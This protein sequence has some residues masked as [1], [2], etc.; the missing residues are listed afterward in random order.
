MF[1]DL[2]RVRLICDLGILVIFLNINSHQFRENV[3][4]T[5]VNILAAKALHPR[6]AAVAQE[7]LI[8]GKD[9]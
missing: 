3:E 5:M 8:S 1:F 6:V 4:F 7:N 2:S 9:K